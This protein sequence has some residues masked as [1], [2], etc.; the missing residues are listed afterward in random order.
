M[1]QTGCNLPPCPCR[2]GNPITVSRPLFPKIKALPAF[3][4]DYQGVGLR[5]WILGLAAIGLTGN[6]IISLNATNRSISGLDYYFREPLVPLLQWGGLAIAVLVGLGVL[7]AIVFP[8]LRSTVLRLLPVLAI[9]GAGLVWVELTRALLPNPNRIYELADL[10]FRPIN[11]FGLL[12]STLFIGYLFFCLPD[13]K[14]PP[15]P[16][17][18]I[19]AALVAAFYLVQD[20]TFASFLTS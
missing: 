13:G 1:P 16:L 18:F 4:G 20:F 5:E 15:I 12:G 2:R 10:P 8:G 17:F 6:Q 9:T 11:N 7:L 14:V 19:R 3:S